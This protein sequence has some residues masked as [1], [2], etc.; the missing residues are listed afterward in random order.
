M[1][2]VQCL[3]QWQ[4]LRQELTGSIGFVPT[5]GNLHAGHQSLVEQSLKENELTV[6]SLFVNPKQFNNPDDFTH[7]PRTLDEDLAL[8]E[9]LGVDYC[10][11]PEARELYADNY[12]YVLSESE[13][14]LGGEGES[15]PGH[16][17]GMLTVVLK[18]FMLVRPH[19]SYFGEKDYQQ[20]QLINGMSEA[21]FLGV[22]V[23]PCPIVREPSGL[24]MSSRNNRL[25]C[26]E[27]ELADRFANIFHQP[28]KS[29]KQITDEIIAARIKVDYVSESDRRR[30]AAVFIGEVRLIDNYQLAQGALS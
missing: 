1:K 19:N 3:K 30:F 18:L 14:S 28:D 22:N 23:V 9:S 13:L 2:T 8:L 21:L 16:F 25:S 7:Y 27:R 15:R 6:V 10:V 29:V 20:Y 17:D 12:R 26:A 11:T 4:S 5:M 24:A